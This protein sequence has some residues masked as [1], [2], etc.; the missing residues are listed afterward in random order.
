MFLPI[1]LLIG[2][3]VYIFWDSP[4]YSRLTARKLASDDAVELLKRRYI[5]GEIDEETYRKIKEIINE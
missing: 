3:I 1:L 5:K 2:L 4:R